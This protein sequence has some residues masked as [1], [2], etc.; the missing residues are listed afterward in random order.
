LAPRYLLIVFALAGDS[1]MTND[2]AMFA[3]Y[4]VTGDSENARPRM[5]DLY[6]ATTLG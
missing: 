6:R 5:V 1:T 3:S 2:F 4:R